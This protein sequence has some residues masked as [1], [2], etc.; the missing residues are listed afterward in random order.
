M[1]VD[2]AILTQ[3]VSERKDLTP[4]LST[5]LLSKTNVSSLQQQP[6]QQTT[7]SIQQHQSI[8]VNQFDDF[9]EDSLHNSKRIQT[10]IENPYVDNILSLEY[11]IRLYFFI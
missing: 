4:S 6:Q 3:P 8:T 11:E 10:K 2:S 7:T 1:S 9:E 5:P